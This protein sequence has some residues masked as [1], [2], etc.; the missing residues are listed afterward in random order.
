MKN[1]TSLCA[2]VKQALLCILLVT[3]S[4]FAIGNDID[5]PVIHPAIPI[6]DESGKHVLDSG[7]AYSAKMT[8]GTAGCHDYDKITHA[9]HFEMGRDEAGDKF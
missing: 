6:L 2:R 5:K 9:Y 1:P 7:A 3:C 8:C 4:T